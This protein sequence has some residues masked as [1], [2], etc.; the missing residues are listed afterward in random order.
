MK[1]RTAIL[2]I[3]AIM[4]LLAFSSASFAQSAVAASKTAPNGIQNPPQFIVIGS[5]DN[6][7]A[8]TAKWM[9]EV[10]SSGTNKDGSKR[11]MSFY[12]NTR[13]SN[14]NVYDWSNESNNLAAT[15]KEIYD[16]GHEVSN[17][18]HKHIR[19]VGGTSW[20][21]T[22][23]H[24]NNFTIRMSANDIF[25]DM[26][27][28]K[29]EMIEAG[30]PK[31]HQ[32][33]FRTPFLAYSDSAFT[34]MQWIGFL[35]DCSINAIG[36][37]GE[38]NWPYTLDDIHNISPL[39]WAQTKGNVVPDNLSWY[40]F[41]GAARDIVGENVPNPIREHKGLWTLPASGVQ[42][43]VADRQN[44][45]NERRVAAYVAGIPTDDKWLPIWE[46]PFEELKGDWKVAGLDYNIWA[47]GVFLDSAETVRALMFTLKQHLNGNRAPFAYGV[48]SQ[49]YVS[50]NS[51]GP[52]KADGKEG[53]P[54]SPRTDLLTEQQMKGSFE[55]FVKLASQLDNVFFVSGDMV[56]AWMEDPCEAEDFT[57]ERYHRDT[58]KGTKN[59]DP[60]SINNKTA[61]TAKSVSSAAFA[62]IQN[63]QVNL[64]LT[65]GNY[66]VELYN[67]K[68]RLIRK[69]DINAI[70]G[71]NATGLTTDRLSRG[72]FVLNVKQDGVS[73]LS[74]KISIK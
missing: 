44:I 11:Y 35:Y 70:N 40:G 66:S 56:I 61:K 69:V 3:T 7:N 32:F 47:E 12:S 23:N 14:Q 59:P 30:I 2:R 53:R 41:G 72:V 34:A 22:N 54:L 5:D 45:Y 29:D 73:V 43:D 27:I 65:A 67:L 28:A 4:A 74:H 19:M 21:G 55:E 17:H 26:K 60:I 48:H 46:T 8:A 51:Y 64:Q 37:P 31:E 16:L 15:H 63:G 24:V 20:S 13:N 39:H 1:K 49:Y 62:G 10:I 71:L 42:P 50:E 33:G 57:V 18:T 38:H 36:L 25:D 58:R 68:G 6:T 9:A 52:G